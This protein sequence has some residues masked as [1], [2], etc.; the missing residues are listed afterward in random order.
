MN[1][2]RILH[3]GLAALSEDSERLPLSELT[4]DSHIHGELMLQFGG[5]IVPWLG[6]FGAYDVC[7][8]SW[9]EELWSVAQAFELASNAKYIF[10]EGEQGQ[11]AFVF[12]RDRDRAFFS[13]ADAEFSAGQADPEWQRVEFS[14]IEFLAEHTRFRAS[15]FDK[16]RDEAPQV[17]DQWISQHDPKSRNG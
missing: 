15:F 4:P 11:P 2:I 12:E 16:L 9:L 8:N 7:F 1:E 3:E 14:P 6:F 5:R 13:I 10:D 17:V